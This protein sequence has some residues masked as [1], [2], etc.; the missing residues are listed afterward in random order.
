MYRAAAL[1]CP[2]FLIPSAI[3]AGPGSFTKSAVFVVRTLL[4]VFFGYIGPYGRAISRT[5]AKGA[6]PGAV[7]IGTGPRLDRA[8]RT[9]GRAVGRRA[10]FV[11]RA[12]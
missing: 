6:F 9:L 7:A 11:A 3:V 12:G 10:L 2:A 4:D 5:L 8:E 1:A